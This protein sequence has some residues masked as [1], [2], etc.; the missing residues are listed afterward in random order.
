[1]GDV[2]TEWRTR[3]NG[4]DRAVARR[5]ST[6][7]SGWQLHSADAGLGVAC[8][9]WGV[10]LGHLP[11]S[12]NRLGARFGGRGGARMASDVQKIQTCLKSPATV[13]GPLSDVAG[14]RRHDH[15]QSV[16][17]RRPSL[18][19][20]ATSIADPCP[21]S[22]S[23]LATTTSLGDDARRRRWAVAPIGHGFSDVA[24]PSD[25]RVAPLGIRP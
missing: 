10:L 14:A 20:S 25:R 16:A 7:D 4:R 19:T 5:K 3:K 17:R 6:M 2:N 21:I 1:M 15:A 8:A 24:S 23:P 13:A 12:A 9:G 11:V 22:R 18:G